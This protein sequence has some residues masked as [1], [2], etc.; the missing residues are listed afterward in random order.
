VEIRLVIH[1]MDDII[2]R[3]LTAQKMIHVDPLTE[4][5]SRRF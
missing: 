1:A 2:T 4:R 5:Y 3:T